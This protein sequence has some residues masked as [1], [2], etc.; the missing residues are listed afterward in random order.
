VVVSAHPTS[1][2]VGGP[3]LLPLQNSQIDL[4]LPAVASTAMSTPTPRALTNGPRTT[5]VR[6][7]IRYNETFDDVMQA[8]PQEARPALMMTIKEFDNK[9][10]KLKNG[11]ILTWNGVIIDPSENPNE[12]SEWTIL[13]PHR[14]L[15][16][17][18][19]YG[20]GWERR[21]NGTF[22]AQSGLEIT[23]QLCVIHRNGYHVY[24]DGTTIAP[25]GRIETNGMKNSVGIIYRPGTSNVEGLQH[26]PMPIN[27]FH[28]GTW[29]SAVKPIRSKNPISEPRPQRRGRWRGA[30]RASVVP[31]VRV[32]TYQDRAP[33]RATAAQVYGQVE[34]Y[35]FGNTPLS[36]LG[37][38]ANTDQHFIPTNM[39]ID[40][41]DQKAARAKGWR[42]RPQRKM[43]LTRE[44]LC[45]AV[46]LNLQHLLDDCQMDGCT[47]DAFGIPLC[48]PIKQRILVVPHAIAA[49][50]AMN[51]MGIGPHGEEW[52]HN[53]PE[54]LF[55]HASE[56]DSSGHLGELLL[57]Y[58]V[59]H[60]TPTRL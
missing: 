53:D 20:D 25:S 33:I 5:V 26:H 50:K 43:S 29:N 34:E 35:P 7:K 38:A 46:P 16:G 10:I 32:E 47:V 13:E 6:R 12:P 58:P 59:K 15:D 1:T 19:L 36:A 56:T 23:D 31:Q 18:I 11:L 52:D 24:Q 51:N 40:I 39:L 41:H 57:T 14:R 2:T 42:P 9:S 27:N 60:N 4:V 22:V 37:D 17:S 21:N 48:I 3:P 30:N 49:L 45:R 28:N 54:R 8:A 44:E 55:D